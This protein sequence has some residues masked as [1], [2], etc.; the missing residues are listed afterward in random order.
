VLHFLPVDFREIRPEHPQ[1]DVLLARIRLVYLLLS[2]L[3]YLLYLLLQRSYVVGPDG[4]RFERRLLQPLVVRLEE[5]IAQDLVFFF[6]LSLC[7]SIVF[8]YFGVFYK[9]FEFS[10][11]E[12][13]INIIFL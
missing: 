13:I 7:G 6:D 12:G 5:V 2:D 11:E 10:I 1:T 9:F 3:F 4:L 8:E